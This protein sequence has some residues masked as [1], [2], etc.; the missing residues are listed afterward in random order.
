MARHSDQVIGL[1][2]LTLIYRSIP[3]EKPSMSVF[4][5]KCIDAARQTLQEHDRCLSAIIREQGRTVCLEAYINW[6]VIVN[7]TPRSIFGSH[8]KSLT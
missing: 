7:Y 8:Q 1:S 2:T 5:E 4:C 3:P 6:F